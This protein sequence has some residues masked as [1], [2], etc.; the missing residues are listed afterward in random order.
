MPANQTPTPRFL[1][2]VYYTVRHISYLRWL[3]TLETRVR[4]SSP[5]SPEQLSTIYP[6]EP[7]HQSKERHIGTSCPS[8]TVIAID[9]F[10]IVPVVDQRKR[11]LTVCCWLSR[12]LLPRAL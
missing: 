9:R 3:S 11:K 8:F 4:T 10:G 12:R 5:L 6:M 7:H 2:R 1:T